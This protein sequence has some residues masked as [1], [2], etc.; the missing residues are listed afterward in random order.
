[1]MVL[2]TQECFA[3]G[4]DERFHFLIHIGVHIGGNFLIQHKVDAS[5]AEQFKAEQENGDI[6]SGD[7]FQMHLTLGSYCIDPA[8]PYSSHSTWRTPL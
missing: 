4:V 1:M 6:I 3:T 2:L 7:V 5:A 8:I